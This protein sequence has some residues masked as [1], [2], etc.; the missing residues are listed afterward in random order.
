MVT[1]M[2]PA[3]LLLCC[4][5]LA[6]A[7]ELTGGRVVY[8]LPMGHSL[9]QF[10]ANHLT[11]MHVLQVVTDPTRADV[12]ITD[13]V[14]SALE[15][16]MK[17]LFQPPQASA[18]AKEARIKAENAHSKETAGQP[19]NAVAA[20]SDTANKAEK[21]GN[22]ATFGHGR[23]T[24]FLV[25]VKSRQVLW[26]AFQTPKNFTPRELDHTAERIAKRLKDDL[27]EKK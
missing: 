13:R 22:M 9:D 17:D 23:G 21:Q 11:R 10:L 25:D 14:G 5:N 16:R 24:I 15:D 26:S 19:Q 1:E 3:L 6:A 12:I 7:A 27:A 4:L 2:K 18:E 8:V 20:F